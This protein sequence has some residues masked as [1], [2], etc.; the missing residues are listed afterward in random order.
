MPN[1]EW[2]MEIIHKHWNGNVTLINR[3]Y[4]VMFCHLF[5]SSM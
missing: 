3:V 5:Y 2:N 4:T 1:S